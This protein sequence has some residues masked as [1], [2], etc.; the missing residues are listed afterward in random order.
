MVKTL[1]D[2]LLINMNL[3]PEFIKRAKLLLDDDVNDYL[4]ILD[5]PLINSIRINTLKI[6][7]KE[8]LKRVK[9][10]GWELRNIP[11]N[12]NGYWVISGPE[13]LGNTLEHFLGYYYLQDAASMIP[14]LLMEL[15]EGL[16]I[17]D[18]AASPGSKT[19]QIAELINDEGV[20]IANDVRIDRVSILKYNLQRL[21]VRSVIITRRNGESF[22][23]MKN[24]FDRVL[25]DAPCSGEGVIRR[26]KYTAVQWNHKSFPRFS[27]VQKALI[28]SAFNSLKPGGVLV[29]STCSLAPEENEEVIDYLLNKFSNAHLSSTKINGL[30]SRPGITNWLNKEFN[31]EVTKCSRIYPMDNNTIGFFVAKII[32]GDEND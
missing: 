5:E 9:E 12:R 18:M 8:F 30:K 32:K 28:T 14:P 11:W 17:L 20:I 29:Y 22:G 6:N 23:K 13:K 3:K 31:N 1:L 24:Y 25:L 19:G 7:N 21:G 4:R 26:N 15:N 27:R 10:Q 2:P 16:R